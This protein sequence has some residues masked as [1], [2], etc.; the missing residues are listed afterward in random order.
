MQRTTETDRKS[1]PALRNP[2]VLGW[3]G[4]V[5]TVLAVNLIMVYLA[6][7]TNP[8]LVNPDYYERGQDYERTLIS[9]RARDPNWTMQAD[10]PRPLRVG[11]PQSIRFFLVDKSGQPVDPDAVT[12][13]AYRPSDAA[14]DFSSSMWREG[15]GRYVVEATFPLV[16]VWDLLI[17]A[18]TGEDEYSV[19]ER[20]SVVAR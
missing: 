3:I 11:E 9:R 13:F 15:T 1:A 2:W 16:G 19:G 18:R 14:R 12:F 10:V 4:L 8:G 7:A 20:V 6:I 5:V 17:A